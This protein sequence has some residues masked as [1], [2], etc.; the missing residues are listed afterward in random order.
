MRSL[1]ASVLLGSAYGML[2]LALK[3]TIVKIGYFVIFFFIWTNAYSKENKLT[4]HL[5]F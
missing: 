1:L 3:S 2:Y 5:T 4:P